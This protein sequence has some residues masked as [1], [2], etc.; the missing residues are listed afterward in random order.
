M[1]LF[2]RQA[3]GSLQAA[4]SRSDDLWALSGSLHGQTSILKVYQRNPVHVASLCTPS[5]LYEPDRFLAIG[6]F[7]FI[8]PYTP[9][10]FSSSSS[11]RRQV[12]IP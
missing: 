12:L 11:I 7:C 8:L 5:P 6:L 1:M 10:V 2:I 3:S 9:A 4:S